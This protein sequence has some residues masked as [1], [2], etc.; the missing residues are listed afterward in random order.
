LSTEQAVRYVKYVPLW[1]FIRIDCEKP[2]F[3]EARRMTRSR[4]CAGIAL[5]LLT[6]LL[7]PGLAVAATFSDWEAFGDRSGSFLSA[8]TVNRNQEVFGEWCYPDK[9]NCVWLIGI[10]TQCREGD[11]YPVLANSDVGAVQFEV[12]CLGK[13]KVTAAYELVF[14]NFDDVDHIAR[15]ATRV[16]FAIPLHAGQFHIVRFSLAGA[17]RA[18]TFMREAASSSTTRAK[19]RGTQPE[20]L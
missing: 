14:T 4:G 8:A 13:L 19:G 16:R 10:T 12:R 2:G 9:G 7:V 20:T 3:T 11:T 18:L 15:K 17:V 6:G 1:S 5:N